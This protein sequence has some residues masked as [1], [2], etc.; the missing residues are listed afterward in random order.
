MAKTT[1]KAYQR[2]LAEQAIR[3]AEIQAVRDAKTKE[4][5][6]AEEKTRVRREHAIL[7]DILVGT[8]ERA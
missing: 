4:E 2:R 7:L 3:D 1:S 8:T 5:H 6:D